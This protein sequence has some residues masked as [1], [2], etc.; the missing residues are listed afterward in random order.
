MKTNTLQRR[1]FLSGILKAGSM[2]PLMAAPAILKAAVAPGGE[3]PA[4]PA[5]AVPDRIVLTVSNDLS[6]AVTINWRTDHNF[7]DSYV[8]YA[9]ADAHPEFVKTVT[10]TKATSQ[11]FQLNAI[12]VQYHRIT[13][14]GLQPNTAYTYRVGRDTGWSEWMDFRTAGTAADPLSFIYL[15]DAQVGI[16]PFWSRVVRKAYTRMEQPQLIIHAG[17]LVNRANNDEE[18]GQWFEAGGFIHGSIPGIMAAGNHEYTHE[19]GNPHL[20][21]LWKQQFGLPPNGTGDEALEGTCYYTDVQ[22]VRFI[23]LNTQMVQEA[24]TPQLITRQTTWLEKTLQQNPC[25]WTIVVMHH[26]IYSTKKGRDNVQTRDQFKPLFDQYKVDLVLQGHDH[27]YARGMGKIM[28]HNSNKPSGTMYVVSVSG[29]KMYEC[30]PMPWADV[31]AG[32]LQMYH[33]ITVNNDRLSFRTHLATGALFD[34]FDLLKQKNA[35]N[36][37]V[38]LK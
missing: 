2:L 19:D 36:K 18:W 25:K 23:T 8:E 10:K 32:N 9:P 28:Q 29:A 24:M 33:H 3:A 27:A 11:S 20:S 5:T 34:S 4:Y 35:A 38:A 17:D 21:L 16:R 12:N 37:L 30:E 22:G 15:G 1:K 13:L 31:V 26:P 14:Q 7:T 6:T